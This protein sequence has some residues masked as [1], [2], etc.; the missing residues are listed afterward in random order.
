[1]VE[2]NLLSLGKELS[3][4]IVDNNTTGVYYTNGS[5]SRKLE[6]NGVETVTPKVQGYFIPIPKN[7]VLEALSVEEGEHLDA[8]ILVNKDLTEYNSFNVNKFLNRSVNLFKSFSGIPDFMR[9]RSHQFFTKGWV[10]VKSRT[11]SFL[12]ANETGVLVF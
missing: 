9:G 10:P 6:S 2:I 1:M 8:G 5:F 3:G 7:W 4:F 12:P 11:G